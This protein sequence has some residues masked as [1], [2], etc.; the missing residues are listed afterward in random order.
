MIEIRLEGEQA[1]IA[2]LSGRPRQIDVAAARAMNRSI[3]SAN[4]L[5]VKSVADD[6][7]VKQKD[8]R[9]AMTVTLATAARLVARIAAPF[10]RLWL[11]DLIQGGADPKGPF[12]SRGRRVLRIRGKSYPDAFVARVGRH[13]GI[14][15]RIGAAWKSRGA[16]SKNLPILELKGPSIGRVATKYRPQALARVQ[17]VFAK[18]FSHELGFARTQGGGAE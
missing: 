10:R 17:E 13:W 18:N 7:K 4:S 14:F 6:L 5:L 11:Y 8:V 9:D 15:K 16:W 2:G 12:P 1:V 3:T